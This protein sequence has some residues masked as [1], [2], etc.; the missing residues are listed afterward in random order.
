MREIKKTF[1]YILLLNQ[2]KVREVLL[3]TERL[4]GARL[5]KK[6]KISVSKGFG[7]ELGQ[8]VEVELLFLLSECHQKLTRNIEHRI[9]QALKYEVQR[10]VN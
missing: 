2:L 4:V 3:N 8:R 1:P 10:R 5:K 9:E 6:C 7:F